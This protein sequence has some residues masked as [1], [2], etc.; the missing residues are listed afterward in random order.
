LYINLDL[1]ICGYYMKKSFLIAILIAL[2]IG[3]PFAT[4][5]ALA[6]TMDSAT[7]AAPTLLAPR[8]TQEPGAAAPETA[9]ITAPQILPT[10][11]L[12]FTYGEQT[13]PV[14]AQTLASWKGANFLAKRSQLARPAQS[15][16]DFIDLFLGKTPSEINNLTSFH[17]KANLIYDY[18][19]TLAGKIDAT[20]TEPALTIQENR[21]VEFIPPQTGRKTDL[22]QSTLDALKALEQDQPVTALAVIETAPHASLA[23]QNNFGINELIAQGTSNYSGSPKNRI[24]NIQVGVEKMKGIIIQRGEEFS[25]NKYLGPVDGQH[26]FLPELVI[27]K[28]GT[29]PE[30][31]GGLCQVSSTTFRAAMAAGLPITQ[32]RNHAYAVSYYAPQGTDATIYPGVVDLK[33]VNDTPGA[34]LV[35][36][37]LKDKNILVFDF[38]GTKDSRQVTLEKPLQWD[39]KAD[40]SMKA[41]WTREVFQ[42]GTTT[43]DTFKSVYQSPALFH[44]TE[45]FAK[46]TTTAA[47]LTPQTQ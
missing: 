44:K 24:H 18:V 23:Q 1:Y 46:P 39:R 11:S 37:Y 12:T 26:G 33:F 15:V 28:S 36:P 2:T 8:G 32:R 16:Q 4:K 41:S 35:W 17:Y 40:G 7:S 21:A 20:S 9:P 47:T 19:K 22:F 27:K 29:V 14:P 6:L 30:F 31:G 43:T 5:A 25:F 34:I 10:R 13:F 45:E 42:N 3:G 38:Y